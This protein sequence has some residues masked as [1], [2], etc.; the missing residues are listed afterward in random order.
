MNLKQIF[1]SDSDNDKLDKVNYNFDQILANG[2]GPVGSQGSAGAQGFTGFQGDQGPQ[3]AQ[4]IQ[5]AQGANGADGDEFWQENVGLTNSTLVPIH[6]SQYIN[7]PT[8]M[9]GVDFNDARYDDV[10]EDVAL[11]INKKSSA[12]DYNL[13]LSDDSAG[14]ARV[15]FKVSTQN[16]VVTYFEGF[17]I[18]NG[19]KKYGASK[20]IYGNG[21]SEFVSIG[22]SEFKVNVNTLIESS[23]EFKGAALKV[24]VGNPGIDKIL[25]STDSSGTV[26]WK[27]ITELQAG[28][29]VGTIVPILT[30]VFDDNNNFDKGFTY[31]TGTNPKLQIAFG[32]GINDYEGWYLCHG[33]T[34]IQDTI[35]GQSYYAV[36]NLSSFSYNISADTNN[37][38][39]Q[40]AAAK[41]D[42]LLAIP[43]G[44]DI[45][46]T[47]TF[48]SGSYT[49]TRS[50]D[51]ASVSVY[52]DTTGTEYKLYKMVYVVFLG[53][54][55]LYWQD[56]G[57]P[58]GTEL[59]FSNIPF[60]YS[61]QNGATNIWTNA[62]QSLYSVN[63]SLVVPS[64]NSAFSQWQ[65][66]YSNYNAAST[67]SAKLDIVKA[68]WRNVALWPSTSGSATFYNGTYTSGG[69][70]TLAD[71]GTYNL[72]QYL[73]YCPSAGVILSNGGTALEGGN[74]NTG[75]TV[76][77]SLSSSGS[78]TTLT[79]APGT[80]VNFYASKSTPS[81]RASNTGDWQWEI[82]TNGTSWSSLSGATSDTFN[83]VPSDPITYYRPTFRIDDGSGTG[84]FYIGN[85]V[86]VTVSAPYV[87]T[88]GTF[89]NISNPNTSGYIT[90]NNAPVDI[91]LN[92]FGGASSGSS[93][94]ATL[95]VSF[96]N[97]FYGS[98]YAT[99]GA[100]S[101]QTD[102]ITL[103]SN[104]TYTYSLYASYVG[105][106][107]NNASI[108]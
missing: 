108:N 30:S 51:T 12:L 45:S 32:K 41:T 20:F 34:W 54:S 38:N 47:A 61:N 31:P 72:D 29:P 94:A 98:A 53:K 22:S 40:G 44:A 87:I 49:I 8:I 66:V 107:G 60:Y 43:G 70:N 59:V 93:T 35:N 23:S 85:S 104:G 15:V 50:Q 78:L 92:A 73:R 27:S 37:Q 25:T 96:G 83:L 3:G 68:A 89:V 100:Y 101:N 58:Q 65:T 102:T 95:T 97:T 80:L 6:D 57:T 14:S 36:P 39:G 33:E 69:T 88:G 99:A 71:T 10:L 67:P 18:S 26:A 42:N 11:L 91:E 84:P 103:N 105:S 16:S 17:N 74:A 46:M 2:G 55:D 106:S 24:N 86:Q 77:G 52:S 76:S 7:P 5:G 9:I 79:V 81:W 90:V 13:F 56:P 75:I 21:Q 64:S 62:L 63:R 4:G 1:I 82:S 28:V 48:N 19:V